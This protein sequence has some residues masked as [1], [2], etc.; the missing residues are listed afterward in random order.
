VKHYG[1]IARPLTHFL[2]KN[3]FAWSEQTRQPFEELKIAMTSTPILAMPDFNETFIIETD[4]CDGGIGAVLV[5]KGQPIA[6]LSKALTNQ[7]KHLS[8]YEKEFLALIMAVD[9][10]RQYL[11]HQEFVIKTDHKSLAYLTEQ[12]LHSDMQK[13]AMDRL[14]GLKFKVVYK[15]GKDNVAANALSRMHHLFALQAI[16]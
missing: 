14:M 16:S 9:K 6:F 13:K 1:L 2:K 11:Q 12:N 5:Q 15:E 7:H 3:Q 4:A 8:I 10:W